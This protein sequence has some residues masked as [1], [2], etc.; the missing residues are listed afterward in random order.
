MRALL[1]S[2]LIGLVLSPLAME[3]GFPQSQSHTAL[4]K[5]K[6]FSDPELWELNQS[7]T[8][9]EFGVN[10]FSYP[11]T[12]VFAFDWDIAN[13]TFRS[14]LLTV[15]DEEWNRVVRSALDAS[16]IKALGSFGPD[17][18]QFKW[19]KS[20]TAHA[21]SDGFVTD[22]FYDAYVA[23]TYNNRI[24]RFVYTP[25][26]NS[27]NAAAIMTGNGLWCPIDIA[28]DNGRSY[29]PNTDDK[30]WVLNGHNDLL[31]FG[32]DGSF[33]RAVETPEGCYASALVHSVYAES[34]YVADTASDKIYLYKYSRFFD[35][36]VKQPR[37]GL[38]SNSV[39]DLQI[40][41]FGYVWALDSTSRITKY[42]SDLTPLCYFYEPDQFETTSGFSIAGGVMGSCDT[43]ICETWTPSSGIQHYVIGTD[44]LDLQVTSDQLESLHEI[45]YT[46]V[47]ASWVD[48]A[49]YEYDNYD[50]KVKTL[51]DSE[52][53]YAGHTI[54]VW[55][56][57]DDLGQQVPTANYSFRITST[58][59]YVDPYTGEPVNQVVK[60]GAFYHVSDPDGDGMHV[61]GDNCPLAYN[62][63]QE[64]SDLN[65]IGDS[66]DFNCDNPVAWSRS[67]NSLM[68]PGGG[69]NLVAETWDR[70]IIVAG[71]TSDSKA[72]VFKCT[73]CGS[74]MW[75]HTYTP[76]AGES[77]VRS[78]I[79]TQGQ[80]LLFAGGAYYTSG[81]GGVFATNPEGGF[82]WAVADSALG[83]ARDIA[84]GSDGGIYVLTATGMV[85][86][87][88]MLGNEIWRRSYGPFTT[89]YEITAVNDGGFAVAG[90]MVNGT[91]GTG[92]LVR[93]NPDGD[94][95]WTRSFEGSLTALDQVTGGGFILV[96]GRDWDVL[97]IRTDASGDTLWTRRFVCGFGTTAWSVEELSDRFY[98]VAGW[99]E[100]GYSPEDYFALKLSPEGDSV[101]VRTHERWS[102]DAAT[103]IRQT[104]DGG[105]LLGGAG[106]NTVL[107]VKM[108]PDSMLTCCLGRRGNVNGDPNDAINVSDLTYLIDYTFKGGPAP[109]CPEEADIDGNAGAINVSDLTYFIAYLFRGGSP[110]R[111]CPW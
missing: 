12:G 95:L 5:E 79:E 71:R 102:S 97:A 13:W 4:I 25:G 6:I 108:E 52:P 105:Y 94:T 65:G 59:S 89:A 48:A 56:G 9:A 78:V 27:L 20:I 62:P 49:I 15:V 91:E 82:L 60:T 19:P 8:N 70:G 45:S 72:R 23:D 99:T 18:N 106:N 44:I 96:G 64:D 107:V 21:I 28:I 17:T 29:R 74:I 30:I 11:I 73:P 104:E 37:E 83:T 110:P 26:P 41:Y 54:L 24:Y 46:A 66:C 51:V 75:E 1:Y 67:Y 16:E 111:P 92:L 34:L 57:T 101:G 33:I 90:Y 40:D 100:S 36:Y 7:V 32:F 61:D 98:G 88:N 14:T 43:Y 47:D 63:A 103:T 55:D 69:K 50:A 85:V 93:A 86:K 42:D 22:G 38:T 3:T 87:L 81:V 35:T 39:V 2:L 68:F 109:P 84:E 80:F 10:L 53:R 31:N 58:S 76:W 77:Q